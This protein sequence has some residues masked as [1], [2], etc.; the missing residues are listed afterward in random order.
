M[1]HTQLASL[2]AC[3]ALLAAGPA[4]AKAT[5]EELA[6]LGSR[7]T[8]MGAERAGNADGSIPEYSGKWLG[9]PPGV[10]FAGTGAHP[11]DAYPGDKPLF[12]ITAQNMQQ[13]ADHLSAGEKELFRL[14]PAT[15]QMPVY[16]SRRDFRYA[17]EVCTSMRENAASATLVDGGMG[18]QATTGSPPFPFPKS[19]LEL[20]WNTMLPA[21]AHTEEATYDNAFVQRD[22]KVNWGRVKSNNFAPTNDLAHRG[23]TEGVQNYYLN[24]TLLPL[25]DKGEI[26]T[27]LDFYN[28]TKD[29]RQSWRYDPGTRRVRQSP[30]YG[31]DMS[32]PGTGGS[33]TV[34]EIR[35]FNGGP[36]RFEWTI[37]GKKEMYIPYNAYRI[38]SDK[39]RYDE[40][41]KPGHANPQHMRYELHRVWVLEGKLKEGYRH[42]YGKRELYIDEDT[43]HAVLA[44]NYDTRGTIWRTSMLN[45]FYAYEM[46]AW[47]A[48]VGLYHDLLENTYLALNLINEQPKGYKLNASSFRPAMFGPEAARRGG[49]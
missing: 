1:K 46:N 2:F 10:A 38:H 20:L 5:A 41:I 28:Y 29:P 14:Y 16:P 47:Q 32:Y 21:R 8:C 42:L 9:A 17:D 31:Y 25:R 11:V 39:V 7:Y 45:Y 18:L 6:Q 36:D 34:D 26:N 48:G 23:K 22:G 27:G 19:G 44:D 30:G 12:T 37:V 49:L 40:L 24:E 3:G 35:L 4:L 33:V 13:Y 43:W 15:F